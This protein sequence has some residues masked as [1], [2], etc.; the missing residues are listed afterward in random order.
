[1]NLFSKKIGVVFLKETSDA[2]EFIE[3]MTELLENSTGNTKTEIEKQIRLASYGV[4]GEKNVAYE[5]KS[6]G[7]DMYVLHDIYFEYGE[8]TAQIDYLVITRKRIYI[9]ECKNLIGNIEVD[10]NGNFI[11][12][13]ELAGKHIKEGFYSPIT[14]NNRHMQVLKEIRKEN[15]SNFLTKILFEKN[16]D[17]KYKSIIVLANPKTYLNARFAKKEI[18]EQ[19]I[20]A[21]Q[22]I[23]YIRKSDEEVT[24]N[25]MSQDEML[26]LA[27]FYLEK[28]LPKKSDYTKKYEEMIKEVNKKELTEKND[29]QN[30]IKSKSTNNS[31]TNANIKDRETLAKKL[32]AYRLEQSRKENIKPYFIFN[33]AQMNDLIDKNPKNKEELINVSG[34]GAVKIEKYGKE[35]LELLHH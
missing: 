1:M 2:T 17:Y 21:D 19:I 29:T 33:D 11:R 20:R 13:Y 34:F 15:K 18:K 8:I 16:F 10:N 31:I 32:K 12:T 7:M 5:L 23:E 27:Q 22:L 30:N 4:L 25:R 14:Q 3:K 6:S 28:S 26:K 9:L 35:I 24:E